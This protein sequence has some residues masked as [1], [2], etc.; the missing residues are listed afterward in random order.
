MNWD[1]LRSKD[2]WKNALNEILDRA[3]TALT[4]HDEEGRGNVRQDLMTFIDK[5]PNWL[6]RDLDHI[7]TDAFKDIGKE[8]IRAAL[9]SLRSRSDTLRDAGA[10]LR[11][12]AVEAH[13]AAKVLSLDKARKVTEAA[14]AVVTQ[15]RAT[16][17][18][19]RANGIDEA[20]IDKLTEAITAVEDLKTE[21]GD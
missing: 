2:D 7:A 16:A 4:D 19:L 21:L 20:T 14:T 1:T 6:V 15:L 5:S 13:A 8:D 9:T 17:G 18:T 12:V 3:A 11:D 10:D